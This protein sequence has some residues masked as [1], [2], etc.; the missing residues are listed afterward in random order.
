MGRRSG[1]KRIHVTG[2]PTQEEVR[3]PATVARIDIAR[4][5]RIVRRA[6]VGN[7]QNRG[8]TS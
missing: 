1:N 2:T 3:L 8:T 5:R 4:H 7:P 6:V